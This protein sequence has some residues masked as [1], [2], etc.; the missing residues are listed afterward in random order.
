MLGGGAS[1]VVASL[2]SGP[3][4]A[5]TT[6]GGFTVTALAEAET[7]QYEQ[8]NLP[9][10]SD[11]SLEFDAG[12]AATS[13][14]Y[15]PTGNAVASTLY[16]GQVI[17]NAGPELSLLV[18]GIPVPPAPVW[19]IEAVSDYPQTPNSASTDQ[20]G[21]NM[22]AVSTADSNT[23]TATLGDDAP[24][25]GS[26]GSQTGGT[27][28]SSSGNP[29]GSSSSIIGIAG[30]SGTSS[31]SAPGA[32]AVATATSSV[33]GISLLDGFV[34]IGGVTT[35]AE[36]SSDGTTGTVT[37]STVLSNVNIAGESVTIDS[38][39][40][41]AASEKAL[42]A[43]PI[44]ALNTIL[45]ELGITLSL[46]SPT[47]VVSGASA[48]RTL[49][50]L[51]I[52]I[53]LDTL[54]TAANKFASLLP[55]SL[56]SKLPIPL[57]NQQL[58]SLNLATV[59]VSSDASPSFSDTSSAGTADAGTGASTGSFTSPSSTGSGDDLG[60][61]GD[62]GSGLGS[63]TTPSGS[64]SGTTPGATSPTSEP[65]S[66]VT[67]V[68]KGIGAGLILLGLAAAAALAYGYKRVDD[69]SELVGPACA[70]GDP[71]SDRFSDAGGPMTNEADFGP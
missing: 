41:H 19:P 62:T 63:A 37:G 65:T 1:L 59:Q 4:G 68:F 26:P 32:T 34:T 45:N 40:I 13:D 61:T 5:D 39:G 36:A 17:A 10:P 35:T 29:L 67:P 60:G 33:S 11:P 25:A 20:A 18:P 48:S 55:A 52:A 57:P 8:P 54:D 6:L 31:S 21:V 66:A 56:T 50:G 23:A 64:T 42:G 28:S 44:A 27:A 43:V 69:V 46:T 70:D 49:D 22:D 53:N 15:G 58:L 16:P 3:A 2:S 7:A 14:N 24:A 30:L 38:G 12:Y 51:K 71:L 9:L 47:D